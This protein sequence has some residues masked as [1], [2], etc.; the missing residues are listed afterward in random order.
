[1][2]RNWINPRCRLSISI[3]KVLVQTGVI[4]S[5]SRGLFLCLYKTQIIRAMNP[6]TIVDR[7]ALSPTPLSPK[8]DFAHRENFP[9]D[10]F[11]ILIMR[12]RA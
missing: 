4:L 8:G 1:M 10:T 7:I 11:Y 5:R 12:E 3:G 2:G 9:I 6:G